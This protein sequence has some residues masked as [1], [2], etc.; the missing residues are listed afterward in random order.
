MKSTGKLSSRHGDVQILY[1]L[2]PGV[3]YSFFISAEAKGQDL[4]LLHSSGEHKADVKTH[5]SS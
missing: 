3:F 4:L 5:E 2:G 1:C